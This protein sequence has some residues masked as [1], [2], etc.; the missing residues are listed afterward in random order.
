MMLRAAVAPVVAGRRM[1]AAGAPGITIFNREQKRM[2]RQRAAREPEST[3]VDYLRDEI[4][5]RC[6][7]R[8]L[9]RL[10]R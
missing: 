3:H 2:Q 10:P 6:A 1:L 8:L 9:V 7:D 5:Q 4:A